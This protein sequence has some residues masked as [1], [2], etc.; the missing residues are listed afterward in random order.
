[1]IE[2]RRHPQFPLNGGCS[3]RVALFTLIR[4]LHG[5]SRVCADAVWFGPTMH[6]AC[7]VWGYG[8]CKGFACNAACQQDTVTS[9]YLVQDALQ[10]FMGLGGVR[11]ESNVVITEDGRW[12]L[13]VNS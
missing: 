8:P 10:A 6:V 2:G 1:M 5:Y 13:F 7:A 12:A 9:Q 11:I 4:L 3:L